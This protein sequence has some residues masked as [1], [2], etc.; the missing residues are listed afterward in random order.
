MGNNAINKT[1]ERWANSGQAQALELK[2]IAASI[3]ALVPGNQT[4][5]DLTDLKNDISKLETEN[6]VQNSQI[7]DIKAMLVSIQTSI[8]Q[9]KLAIGQPQV[10]EIADKE[11][12]Y[13]FLTEIEMLVR[14]FKGNSP[15]DFNK[16]IV[17][18]K[19]IPEANRC[20]SL[21]KDCPEWYECILELLNPYPEGCEKSLKVYLRDV[22]EKIEELKKKIECATAK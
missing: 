17:S 16:C 2:N 13:I 8:D 7:T 22:A 15:E 1:F 14:G 9:L 21:L 18:Y 4:I 20:M 10:C 3:Q 11:A 12:I 5:P 6:A 19:T